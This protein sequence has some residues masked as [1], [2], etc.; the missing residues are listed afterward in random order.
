M[1]RGAINVGKH[2]L[3]AMLQLPVGWKIIAADWSVMHEMLTLVVDGEGL[4]DQIDGAPP[5]PI[6]PVSL[7][8]N[9]Q[10][11]LTAVRLQWPMEPEKQ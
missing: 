11:G 9:T 2:T 4:P 10:G 3:E 8:G 6:S 5:C 7:M 1:K